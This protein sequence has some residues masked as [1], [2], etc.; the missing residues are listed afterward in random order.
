MGAYV[1]DRAEQ[2]RTSV[3]AFGLPAD[4]A[5][6][7]GGFLFGW[8]VD[9]GLVASWLKDRTPDAFAAFADRRLTG[10]ELLAA[11]DGNLL[12]DMFSDEGLAFVAAYYGRTYAEDYASTL[13]EGLPS[14]YH[15]E[16]RWDN[17]DRLVAVLDERLAAFRLT[18]DATAPRIDLRTSEATPAWTGPGWLPTVALP[19]AIALPEATIGMVAASPVTRAAIDHA[20][21]HPPRWFVLR[22]PEVPIGVAAT[23]SRRVEDDH[24]QLQLL[25]ELGPRV[26]AAADPCGP[27]PL[28]G[29]WW[30]QRVM[31]PEWTPGCEGWAAEIR[32]RVGE[33]VAQ[34]RRSGAPPGPLALALARSGLA[35]ID[36]VAGD[37][38]TDPAL[39][40]QVLC[41]SRAD[42][43]VRVVLD[44]VQRATRG[45]GW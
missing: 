38:L 3:A 10:P 29:A 14:E 23:V 41:A 11:W 32:T 42:D 20:V 40:R 44:A 24:G 4:R 22:M 31:D 7:H 25:V 45:Q 12:D 19:D 35:F 36:A 13:C 6:V 30:V 18:Y 16:N 17:Y 37:L 21:H 5:M 26:R 33:L 8:A 43:R 9:R 34:R 1:F 15:V 27:P 2:H 39:R 28:P